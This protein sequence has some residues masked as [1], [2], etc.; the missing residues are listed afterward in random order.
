MIL[1]SILIGAAIIAGGSLIAVF[2][3]DIVSWLKRAV[4]K[5]SQMVKI[6]V[7]GTK[8]FI[9][10]GSKAALEEISI[11]FSKDKNKQWVETTVTREVPAS[12]VPPEIRQRAKYGQQVDITRDLQM[13]LS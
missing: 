3:N 4:A 1:T 7:Y 8:V 11:H 12:K 5:V 10:E 9:R 2:W 13:E 6:A